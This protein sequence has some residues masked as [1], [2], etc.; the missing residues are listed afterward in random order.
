MTDTGDVL[1]GDGDTLVPASK[2]RQECGNIS[3]MTEWRW[4]RDPNLNFPPAVKIRGRK[5]RSRKALEAF[6]QQLRRSE[7]VRLHSAG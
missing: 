1:L 2:A 4:E 7:R 3:P 6:K 5:Y